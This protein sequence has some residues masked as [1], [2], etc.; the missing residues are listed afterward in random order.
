VQEPAWQ[1]LETEPVRAFER[2]CGANAPAIAQGAG[3]GMKIRTVF[4]LLALREKLICFEAGLDDVVLE[5]LKFR[6]M[7][8]PDGFALIGNAHPRLIDLNQDRL[9][10]AAPIDQTEPTPQYELVS[11][12][13]Q[14]YDDIASDHEFRA[15][16]EASLNGSPYVDCGKLL[17]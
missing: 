17:L 10:F 6:L 11:C 2:A 3:K 15:S 5:L 1:E 8:A 13:Q 9:V 7:L 16:L 12:P 4:G 14:A